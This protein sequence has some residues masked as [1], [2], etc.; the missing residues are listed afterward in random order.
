MFSLHK[1]YLEFILL[2]FIS[3]FLVGP[4]PT[5]EIPTGRPEIP[6]G[7]P[8]IPTGPVQRPEG[9]PAYLLGFVDMDKKIR[10]RQSQDGLTWNPVDFPD[11]NSAGGVGIMESGSILAVAFYPKRTGIFGGGHKVLSNIGIWG[12]FGNNGHP[13]LTLDNRMAS[14]SGPTIAKVGANYF[15]AY[16]SHHGEVE[17][18]AYNVPLGIWL[19]NYQSPPNNPRGDRIDIIAKDK[20]LLLTW[21]QDS[22][23]I[24]F[25]KGTVSALGSENIPDVSWEPPRALQ[26]PVQIP[27]PPGYWYPPQGSPAALGSD[28]ERFYVAVVYRYSPGGLARHKVFVFTSGDGTNWTRESAGGAQ[29]PGHNFI[30][31]PPR[32]KLAVKRDGSFFILGGSHPDDRVGG[33]WTFATANYD[34]QT[35]RYIQSPGS[36]DRNSFFGGHTPGNYDFDLASI[37]VQN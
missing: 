15:M 4:T 27:D 37:R 23:Q 3:I 2:L 7:R 36:A 24:L 28:G 22:S 25:A 20:T 32:V 34:A 1:N 33:S 6:T 21:L 18:R 14:D 8:D 35:N 12:N 16:S 17:V 29:I 26:I 19:S 30:I 11:V 13:E 10:V 9:K 5:P 31:L